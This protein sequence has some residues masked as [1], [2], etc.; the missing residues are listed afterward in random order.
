MACPHFWL[1]HAVATDS[2]LQPHAPPVHVALPSH[3]PQFSCFAQL[4][5]ASPQ[6]LAQKSA[7]TAH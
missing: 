3:S 4:S 5:V 2:G 6:R 1:P 7:A